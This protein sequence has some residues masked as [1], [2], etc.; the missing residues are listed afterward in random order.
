MEFLDCQ[1]RKGPF[2]TWMLVVIW[3][4]TVNLL[5]IVIWVCSWDPMLSSVC[6]G[7]T[8]DRLEWMV[9]DLT[10]MMKPRPRLTSEA[11]FQHLQSRPG[12]EAEAEG[13]LAQADCLPPCWTSSCIISFLPQHWEAYRGKHVAMYQLCFCSLL[14]RG[15]ESVWHKY[16]D[17]TTG[18]P[19]PT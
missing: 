9:I 16:W 17:S 7:Q 6:L 13:E 1:K 19:R 3:K 11:T 2:V 18:A 5:L 10:L 12:E 4:K 15:W 14:R 8:A